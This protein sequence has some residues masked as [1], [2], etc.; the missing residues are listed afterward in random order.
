VPGGAR[1][2]PDRGQRLPRGTGKFGMGLF[3]AALGMLFAAS[4]LAF[5]LIRFLGLR[6]TYDPRLDQWVVD[7]NVPKLGAIE[8]PMTLWLSTL[9]MLVSSV[10]IHAAGDT[11]RRER[12]VWLRRWLGETMVVSLLFL[13]VQGPAL[14]KLL[15]RHWGAAEGFTALFGLIATLI[16]IHALHVIGGVV[17][18]AV[19][20]RHAHRGRYDH[21]SHGPVTYVAMYWHFLDAVW[22]VMF[23]V[24]LVAS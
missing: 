11:V 17:P 19:V 20:T 21:E 24:L 14:W 3:L 23:A 1:P 6:G 5:V 2:G 12:Q 9:L 15:A 10:T 8:L 4:L 13:A 7:P 18:L 16:V 22:V